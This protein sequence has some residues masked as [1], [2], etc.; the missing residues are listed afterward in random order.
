MYFLVYKNSKTQVNFKNCDQ[1]S[2]LNH[3]DISNEKQFVSHSRRKGTTTQ[4]QK[5][6]KKSEKS[7]HIKGWCAK[8]SSSTAK[9]TKARKEEKGKLVVAG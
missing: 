6:K 1:G 4:N 8:G 5:K 2:P 7:K 3:R 9:I